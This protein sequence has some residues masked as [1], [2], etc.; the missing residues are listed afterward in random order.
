MTAFLRRVA[1]LGTRRRRPKSMK[2]ALIGSMLAAFIQPNTVHAQEQDV[3][4]ML[5]QRLQPDVLQQGSSADLF[6]QLRSLVSDERYASF[7]NASS[8]NQNFNGR[9]NIPEKLDLALGDNRTS[10]SSNWEDRRSRFLS[11]NFQDT[12]QAFRSSFFLSQ[13]KVAAIREIA[14]CGQ[15]MA[16]AKANGVFVGLSEISPNRDSFSI[17]MAYRT[18][19]DPKWKLTQFAVQPQDPG[20]SCAN[21]Y[22][23][24]SIANPIEFGAMSRVIGCTKS[25]DKHL[26]LVV[27]TTAGG[28]TSIPLES[29]DEQIKKLR[30]DMQAQIASLSAQIEVLKNDAVIVSTRLSNFSINVG[31]PRAPHPEGTFGAGGPWGP[32]GTLFWTAV[33]NTM[34]SYTCPGKEVLAGLQFIMKSDGVGRHPAWIQ[35]ICKSLGP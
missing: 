13:M 24:A 28:G 26:T 32:G 25:P 7:S 5:A 34:V 30:D 35:Y 17:Q 8:S 33:D 23:K 10:N 22:E 1:L 12:S 3:C 19:G 15:K 27:D 6:M 4:T 9:I 2:V 14:E 11:M 21:A 16:N 31:A 20:F 18:G 29:S